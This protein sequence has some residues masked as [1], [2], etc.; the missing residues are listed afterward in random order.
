MGTGS[1]GRARREGAPVSA[2]LSSSASYAAHIS[3]TSSYCFEYLSTANLPPIRSSRWKRLEA[4]AARAVPRAR[5]PSPRTNACMR[6]MH[7]AAAGLSC[8]AMAARDRPHGLSAHACLPCP[9]HANSARAIRTAR[10]PLHSARRAWLRATAGTC[11]VSPP[12]AHTCR[13]ASVHARIYARA[14]G[15][16]CMCV[17]CTCVHTHAH[18]DL[19]NKGTDHA[20]NGTDHANKGTDHANKGPH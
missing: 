12:A 19:A 1:D 10:R 14:G 13:T 18:A 16:M 8:P 5:T 11:R 20:S 17:M 4:A 3:V 6:R 7:A 15:W 9:L 2:A